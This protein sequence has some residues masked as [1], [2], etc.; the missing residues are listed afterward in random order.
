MVKK[1]QDGRRNNG[2]PRP[3]VR[4]NDA[5]GAQPGDTQLPFVP[6]PEQ[7]TFVRDHAFVM[8]HPTLAG[9]MGISVATLLRHFRDEIDAAL[10]DANSVVA[11]KLWSKIKTG[12]LGAIIWWE[13]T[14]AG[15]NPMLQLGGPGGGPIPIDEMSSRMGAKNLTDEQLRAIEQALAA[16]APG[17]DGSPAAGA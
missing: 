16:L 9:Q 1:V 8:T 5:R 11:G 17:G 6:T 13:K 14:R 7:K 10:D 2:G 15:R 3:K 4:A 12:D